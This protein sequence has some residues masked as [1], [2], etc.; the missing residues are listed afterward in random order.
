LTERDKTP[1][2]PPM[3]RV[4]YIDLERPTILNIWG[5]GWPVMI[6]T[7]STTIL[8]LVDIFWIGKLGAPQV[9]GASLSSALFAVIIS[10]GQ[11]ISAGTLAIIAR[12]AGA[13]KGEEI[14]IALDHSL[15]LALLVALPIVAVGLGWSSS[16]LTGLGAEEVV[17]H[18][19]L[20]YLRLL[21]ATVP[22]LY[23]ALVASTTLYGLGNTRTPMWINLLASALNMALDPLFI[24]GWLGFPRWGVSG[25]GVATLCS[26]IF[27]CA[28]NLRFLIKKQVLLMKCPHL[29]LSL[30]SKILGIGFPA[31]I[32]AVTR[33]L[34]GMALFR[35]TALFGTAGIAAFG[36]GVRIIGIPFIYLMGLGTAVQTLVGQN[37]G[38]ERPD[39]AEDV[40]KKVVKIGLLLQA[41]V[42]ALYFVWAPQMMYAFNPN[43]DVV[44]MGASY[45][46]IISL[47]LLI[48]PY[49]IAWS[50]AQ[51]G[52]GETAPPMIAALLS[53]WAIK[54]PLAFLVAR[55][56]NWGIDGVW[57][58]IG[59]SVLVEALCLRAFYRGGRWKRKDL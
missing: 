25:A 38:A 27:N 16:L 57:L 18:Y 9:A 32:A 56:L 12:Y 19:G 45:L 41:L 48:M 51:R 30:L 53:N 50:G 31:S 46:R 22:F 42:T 6:S 59:F 2:F 58:A 24:F 47:S 21:L 40:V 8:T 14:S 23:I 17:V 11:V 20:P 55:Q 5:I 4:G 43:P 29:H 13:G 33:P 10:F 36:I 3:E 54:I 7:I 52:A 39:R 28:L 37:L 1:I 35:I 49:T 44:R 15:I 34:T 26:F